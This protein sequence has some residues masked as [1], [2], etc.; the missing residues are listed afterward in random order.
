MLF[1]PFGAT[2]VF[3]FPFGVVF[4]IR[5]FLVVNERAP[6]APPGSFLFYFDIKQNQLP[7]EELACIYLCSFCL[8]RDKRILHLWLVSKDK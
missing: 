2:A 8:T 6:A 5:A 3:P 1:M 4:F 7:G